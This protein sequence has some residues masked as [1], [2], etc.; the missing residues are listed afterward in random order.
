MSKVLWIVD[1]LKGIKQSDTQSKDN[2]STSNTG[3]DV[4]LLD[5]RN[6]VSYKN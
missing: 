6:S 5:N 2:N 4:K 3:K 1:K